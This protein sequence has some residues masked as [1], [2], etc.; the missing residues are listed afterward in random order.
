MSASRTATAVPRILLGVEEWLLDALACACQ[1]ERTE[2]GRGTSVWELALDSLTLVS[3]VAQAEI[4]FGVELRV[5]DVEEM[6]CAARVADLLVVV[7]RCVWR[8]RESAGT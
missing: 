7:E 1:R 4:V 2:I 5:E 8:S 6:L 3:I